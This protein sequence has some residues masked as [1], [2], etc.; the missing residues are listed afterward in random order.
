MGDRKMSNSRRSSFSL[1]TLFLVIAAL[2]VSHYVMMRQVREAERK[3][4]AA[5]QELE[6]VRKEFG[7][8]RIDNPQKIYVTKVEGTGASGGNRLRLH[9]PP[10]HRYLLHVGETEYYGT[11]VG[12]AKPIETM[13]MNTWREGADV[14]LHW[15][16][17][18]D[19][20]MRRLKVW[21]DTEELFDVQI[22]DYGKGA[23]LPNSGGSLAAESQREFLPDDRIQFLS[24][25]NDE[26]RRGVVMWMEPL[27][28][29][30][31]TPARP[32]KK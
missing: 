19:G 4:E 6:H 9:I 23:K 31:R 32:A 20:E 22:P 13:S 21:T 14:I 10:G 12:P 18:K 25:G 2:G 11:A 26:T 27:P 28:A 16:M 24:Y 17:A 1:L 7:H 30:M 29:S 8:L 3:V 15:A 5:R